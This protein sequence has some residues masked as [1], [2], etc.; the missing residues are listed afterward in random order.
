M[1]QLSYELTP[2]LAES[3]RPSVRSSV[4]FMSET[5]GLVAAKFDLQCRAHAA[6]PT[7]LAVCVSGTAEMA[8]NAVRTEAAAA[9]RYSDS[10]TSGLLYVGCRV[11]LPGVKRPGRG[12]DHL[13]PYN[14]EV[15]YRVELYLCS[16]SGPS[17]PVPG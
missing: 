12:V 3:V 8:G 17:W 6:V 15:K 16:S 9:R 4:G 5:A 7:V 10:V 2:F 14:A 13:P 1:L 11:Y